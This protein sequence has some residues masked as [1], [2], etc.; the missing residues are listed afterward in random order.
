[1][2][3]NYCRKA[4]SLLAVAATLTGCGLDSLMTAGGNQS[5]PVIAE[6]PAAVQREYRKAMT[7]MLN[8]DREAAEQR[9]RAFIAEHPEYGNAYVNLAI[10]LDEQGETDAAVELLEQ[11]IA[12]DGSNV[13]ALNRIGLMQRR[14]GD[15]AAAE[16]SW[17]EATRVAP[18]YPNAWYN[19]GVLYDLYLRDLT[20]AVDHY[21]RYQDLT[22]TAPDAGVDRWIADLQRRI[23]D[24]PKTANATEA[25]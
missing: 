12:A 17:L 15:F 5:S 13:Y 22:E 6:A 18:D 21:Q 11:A 8:G 10:L 9:L 23:G 4:L 2:L 1:M 14:A 3:C 24:A 16:Q 19:L 25:L 7:L 20:A